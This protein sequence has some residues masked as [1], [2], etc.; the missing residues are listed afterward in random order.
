MYLQPNHI[1]RVQMKHLSLH[2]KG[3]SFCQKD[4]RCQINCFVESVLNGVLKLNNLKKIFVRIKWQIKIR[5]GR[6]CVKRFHGERSHS[7]KLVNHKFSRIRITRNSSLP[8]CLRLSSTEMS[9]ALDVPSI[10]QLR[11]GDYDVVDVQVKT[12]ESAVRCENLPNHMV[13]CP[14]G[15]NNLLYV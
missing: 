1:L 11:S 8:S 6:K 3:Q 10:K 14:F 7:D 5:E 4:V 12:S 2:R 15:I 13:P 9:S